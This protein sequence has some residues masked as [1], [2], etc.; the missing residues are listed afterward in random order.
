MRKSGI[1]MHISSLPSEYGIGTMG[2]SAFKFVDFLAESGQKCW[3][4]LP[5]NPT[6]YGDSPYQSPSAFAGNPYF[7]DI[8][9]LIEE[10]LLKKSEADNY[11]FGDNEENVDYYLLFQNRYPLL[12]T[13]YKRFNKT[14][15]YY[16]FERQNAFW[17]EEFS[18]FMSLKEENHFRSWIYWEEDIK[19]H[20]NEAIKKAKE[21]LSWSI[22]FY[23][24][25]QFK[26]FMQWEKLK[27]Y[28]NKR[29]IEIIGD[30]P[31]YVALDSAEVWSMPHLFLLDEEH[32]P[33]RVA[34]CP[35]DAFC[36]DG[37]LWGNPLYRWDVMKNDGYFWWIKRM[38]M[39]KKLFDRVRIDHFR[40]FEAYYTIPY[41]DENAKNG[42]WEQGPGIEL[43][44]ALKGNVFD[45]SI[46]AEDLGNITDQVRWLLK[47]TGCPGMKVMQFA[48]D[49]CGD[50][51]YLLHHHIEK[52][53]L[54][55]GTHDNDTIRGWYNSLKGDEKAFVNRYLRI[56]REEDAADAMISA[57]LSSVAETVI[58]PIQ[59]Y[60][61]MGSEG[62]MN[63]PSTLGGNWLFRVKK[64]D[65][66]KKLSN[67]IFEYTRTY[68][69]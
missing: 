37:Q 15:E 40:G 46:I 68:R 18:L 13:A 53:V 60:M 27:N 28:A 3:Q 7:I 38:E 36:E 32:M 50:S 44:N 12:R 10:G 58:I 8:P 65:L 11:F 35:P 61:N 47:E 55:T 34:G 39:S 64:G 16:R 51:E 1:L 23:K 14:E 42:C 17:L 59:D 57:V 26:F 49:P 33:I 5:I 30:M 4:V 45:L 19:N 29:G 54:Y 25:L 48:F 20:E 56:K 9:T 69:R 2:E 22:D 43:F 66:S 41:G 31:I 62:R 6:S 52:C 67:K 24:F 21:R 63:T